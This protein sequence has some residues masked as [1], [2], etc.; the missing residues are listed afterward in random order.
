MEGGSASVRA[1]L[2]PCNVVV[3]VRPINRDRPIR[4]AV[5]AFDHLVLLVTNH[6]HCFTFKP[7]DLKREKKERK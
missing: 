6:S 7:L 4:M 1:Y 5:L 3:V 2:D